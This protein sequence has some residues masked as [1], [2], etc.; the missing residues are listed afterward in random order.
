MEAFI[1]LSMFNVD[2]LCVLGRYQEKNRLARTCWSLVLWQLHSPM[3]FWISQGHKHAPIPIQ[4]VTALQPWSLDGRTETCHIRLP[5]LWISTQW[6]PHRATTTKLLAC[7]YAWINW[8]STR[9][10]KYHIHC[11]LMHTQ[12]PQ[13]TTTCVLKSSKWSW[14]SRRPPPYECWGLW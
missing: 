7:V 14:Q 6:K 9:A 11:L 13:S 5:F 2:Q 12:R 8:S 3:F 1:D 4:K 10:W